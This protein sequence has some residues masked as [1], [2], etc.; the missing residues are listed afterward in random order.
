MQKNCKK[1]AGKSQGNN[2]GDL[3][4]SK[5]VVLAPVVQRMDNFIQRKSRYP[6]DKMLQLEQETMR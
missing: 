5:A 2:H 6:P 1:C 4:R 3:F